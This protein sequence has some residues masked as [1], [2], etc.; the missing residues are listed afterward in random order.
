MRRKDREVSNKAELEAIVRQAD[1]CRIAM[2]AEKA[3]YIVPLNFGYEWDETLKL[4]FHCAQTGRKLELLKM[5]DSVGFEIDIGHELIAGS[6]ACDWGM[7]YKSVVGHGKIREIADEED[8]ARGLDSIMKQAG[9]EG[10]PSYSRQMLG[11]VKVLCLEVEE[12]T[13][14]ARI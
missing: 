10:S 9:F 8:K 5:N 12:I 14:K 2:F 4:Y 3:P 11:A 13:G 7:K 6:T 1:V